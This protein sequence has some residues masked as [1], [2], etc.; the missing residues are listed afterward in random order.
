MKNLALKWYVTTMKAFFLGLCTC[1]IS[2]ISF[3]QDR[4]INITAAGTFDFHTRGLYLNDAGFGINLD[5]SAFSKNKLRLLAEAGSD[6]FIGDKLL[7]VD[8]LGNQNK[9]VVIN[10]VKLGLQYFIS[11][12][13]AASVVFGPAWHRISAPG[14]TKDYCYK[15]S[16]TAFL[17]HKEKL[18]TKLFAVNIPWKGS[19][20]RYLGFG[21]GYRIY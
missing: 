11:K 2:A 20:I 9:S 14:F 19:G 3:G 4:F 6:K 5:V 1:L 8:S 13:I 7:H 17:D 12:R 10:S 16:I 18:G 21:I 15:I